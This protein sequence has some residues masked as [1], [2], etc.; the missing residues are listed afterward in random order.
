M[1]TRICFI[2]AVL[3]ILLS[4]PLFAGFNAQKLNSYQSWWITEIQKFESKTEVYGLLYQSSINVKLKL[5]KDSWWEYNTQKY[6]C[7]NPPAGKYE[8]RWNFNLPKNAYVKDLLYWDKEKDTF[9]SASVID[10]TTAEN[11]YYANREDSASVLLRQYMRRDYNGNYNLEYELKISPVNWDETVEFIIKYVSPCEMYYDK[12]VVNDYSY[13]FYS[14]NYNYYTQC[15]NTV[16]AKILTIDYNNPDAAPQNFQTNG[17]Q[18]DNGQSW[19]KNG[20]YW[21]AAISKNYNQFSLSLA[22]E[23][24][25][26]KFLRTYPAGNS[27]FYQLSALPQIKDEIRYPRKIVLAFDLI[28]N[29]FNSYSRENFIKMINEALLISTT[30]KD[31]L[32]FVTSDFDVKWLNN[33]FEQ[34]TENLLNTH[35]NTVVQTV[36]K[37]NTLP[38]MLKDIVKFLNLKNEDA[39]V[40]II[41]DD[42]KTGVRAETVMELLNQTYFSADNK[43]KFNI[44]DVSNSYNSYYIQNKNYRG[45]EYLYENL[46]RI[47]GG[48][49]GST[50][51]TYYKLYIDKVLDCFAPTVSTV[52][53]DP[54]PEA[55]I[56]YSRFDLNKGRNSFNITSRYF[57]IGMFDGSAPFTVNYFG[58][59]LSGSYF[60]NINIVEDNT[61]ISEDILENTLLYWYGNYIL[62]ELFLQPQ[63][64]STIKY[65]EDLAVINHLMTP[66]SGFI[67]PGPTG[68]AGFKRLE[69]EEVT[70][71]KEVPQINEKV[72]PVNIGLTAYPNPFNPQTSIIINLTT[73]AATGSKTLAI[74]NV[75]GQKIRSFDL[76]GYNNLSQIKVDWNGLNDYGSQVSSGTYIAVLKTNESIT[77][78]KLLLIR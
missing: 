64:Y 42:N 2:S 30:E 28:Q 70:D 23:N 9:V 61:N 48:N 5:G 18:W 54:V 40:W 50:Y 76:S 44:I 8:F 33:N 34:R 75:L 77:S 65:I 63:S 66:Y 32:L 55:G 56:S 25:D 74:Y 60:N 52:E 58:N 69:I 16:P 15:N 73:A 17:I 46:S 71:V 6:I 29:Y 1:K 19:T 4:K 38:Y 43:I 14:E 59:Y 21:Q 20:D 13:Q 67:I 22:A 24:A 36:P 31:S 47:S 35:L 7:Q 68:S 72:L 12:R 78:L 49:F 57:E 62:N 11:N 26:G 3:I 37:L 53:I 45:N 41:S 10:L 39:E 51:N 27:N